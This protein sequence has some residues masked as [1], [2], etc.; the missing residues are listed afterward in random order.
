MSTLTDFLY[1][2]LCFLKLVSLHY[3]GDT[4]E[5]ENSSKSYLLLS[6]KICRSAFIKILMDICII[7]N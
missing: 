2:N 6:C 5:S 4:L 3:T 1:K 7:N